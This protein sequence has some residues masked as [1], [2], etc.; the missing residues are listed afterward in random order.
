MV[1]VDQDARQVE[2]QSDRHRECQGGRQE[3]ALQD[4]HAAK[5]AR[6]T[7]ILFRRI[8]DPPEWV[9]RVGEG[10]GDGGGVDR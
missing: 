8:L 4:A 9:G 10:V 6:G 1:G 7:G 3:T 5:G 2:Q